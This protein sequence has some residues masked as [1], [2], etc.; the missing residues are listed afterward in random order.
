MKHCK[1][2]LLACLA[3]ACGTTALLLTPD[4]VSA[5]D[6]AEGKEL[7]K[8]KGCVACHSV[9]GGRL[10]GPDLFGLK[11]R[12]PDRNWVV[13]FIK[14]PKSLNDDYATGLRKEYGDAMP[15]QGAAV[16]DAE[17]QK[18]IDF[19]YSGEKLEVIKVNIAKDDATIELGR[20]YFRGEK[21]FANGGAP[22]IS[23]HTVDDIGIFGGGTLASDV[24]SQ[25]TSLNK[26]HVRNGGDAGL[27]AAISN[28][29]FKVMKNAFDGK[30][31]TGEEAAA[32]TAFLGNVAENTKGTE[33]DSNALMMALFVLLAVLGTG[34]F[35]FG[36]DRV[37]GKRFRG[38]R[39]DI[40]GE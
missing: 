16:S 18:I 2:I 19:L 33:E 8:S 24:G 31:L 23:C 38:V 5:Q 7:F 35:I 37:W 14:D 28:P 12:A 3:I 32:V 13:S 34:V 11:D 36:F 30:P 20:Q 21:Q 26:A 4:R 40:V 39:K 15:A 10:V 1:I 29:Q 9:G 22:C 27:F 6:T 25:F 17:I